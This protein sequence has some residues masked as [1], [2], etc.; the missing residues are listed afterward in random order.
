MQRKVE[1]AILVALLSSPVGSKDTS[2]SRQAFLTLP[3]DAVRIYQ[4][5]EYAFRQG[6]YERALMGFR[7]SG[8]L[9]TDKRLCKLKME[10]LRYEALIQWNL[11]GIQ[12]SSSLFTKAL[13]LARESSELELLNYSRTALA[14]IDLYQQAKEH[15]TKKH[16]SVSLEKYH[17][18]IELAEQMSCDYFKVKCL[19]QMSLIYWDQGNLAEYKKA[20]TNALIIA[21]RENN[22]REKVN[23]FNNIGTYY[24]CQYEYFLALKY[25][26]NAFELAR[27]TKDTGIG[28]ILA[29]LGLIYAHLG[30]FKTALKFLYRSNELNKEDPYSIKY[31]EDLN[32]IGV[33]MMRWGLIEKKQDLFESALRHLEEALIISQKLENIDIEISI[34]NNLGRLHYLNNDYNKAYPLLRRGIKLATR[35]S[36][37]EIKASLY[38]SLASM[39]L[40]QKNS[41]LAARLFGSS[42]YYSIRADNYKLKSE[43]CYGLGKCFTHMNERSKASYYLNKA[44]TYAEIIRKRANAE[45]VKLIDTQNRL[46]IYEELILLNESNYMGHI[47]GE[48]AKDIIGVMERS[49][50]RGFDESNNE[51]RG[52]LSNMGNAVFGQ[53]NE[54]ESR[55]AKYRIEMASRNI[56]ENEKA[57]IMLGL[58]VLEEEYSQ[59]S[60][61]LTSDNYVIGP[62]GTQEVPYKGEENIAYGDKTAILEYFLGKKASWVAYIYGE[63]INIF[64]LA[65]SR[66]IELSVQGFI[67][68]IKASTPSQ[69]IG[70]AA[71]ERLAEELIPPIKDIQKTNIDTLIIIPD[72]IL[73]CI[74][75]EVLKLREG[76]IVRYM[77]EKY[78]ISY[79][80]SLRALRYLQARKRP[81]RYEQIYLGIGGPSSALKRG[82]DNKGGA[83]EAA[84]EYYQEEGFITG[85]IEYGDEEIKEGKRIFGA[86]NAD[87]MLGAQ[88]SEENI[89]RL[90]LENYR[91]VH[92][93]C[94]AIIEEKCPLG[95]ALVLGTNNPQ[96]EDGFLQAREIERMKTCA[97]LVVLSSCH[98]AGG[99]IHEGEGILGLPRVFINCGAQ[100]VLASLWD[101]NDKATAIFMR[102][103][104]RHIAA[105]KIKNE[106]LSICKREMIASR[107]RHPYYWG[108]FI[109]YGEY[110]RSINE[111]AN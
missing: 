89:K 39:E 58:N 84:M 59:R 104:Y 86:T 30:D 2:Q 65:S 106:A 109:L 45:Y 13:G 32:N 46:E 36:N 33:I 9:A 55:I 103:F 51:E 80:Y 57:D 67:R 111:D 35:I 60:R 56:A 100:S 23:C 1:I 77:I 76:N 102:S 105:G 73:N 26:W 62:K 68:A 96:E 21:V 11:G 63:K 4:E 42:L 99:R 44:I 72:G 49:K 87:V 6:D 92:F 12:D 110:D 37:D 79:T 70:E 74:P 43:A 20:N 48:T 31:V 93:A 61:K 69:F 97:N 19:R 66:D 27:L 16:F 28:E 53:K 71:A 47:N 7:K 107:Y 14:I 8:A 15:R 25:F 83:A 18:A 22:D 34:L 95:A 54:L 81:P 78:N 52:V 75:F 41:K 98:S 40:V 64:R 101:I 29:N 38:E 50:Y 94:H 5:S 91:I 24:F 3:Q 17:K 10:S 88:A 90:P 85:G 108:A 82:R